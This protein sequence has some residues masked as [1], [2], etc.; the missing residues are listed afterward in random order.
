LT[1]R[2]DFATR[3]LSWWDDHGRKDLPWQQPRTPYRVWISEIMLQ[4]TQVATVIP[5][6][7]RFTNRFPDIPALAEASQDEVLALWAGLGYYA[8][9]RN[10]HKTARICAE[11]FDA[12]LPESTEEMI[13]LPGIGDSTAN[14]ILS[15]AHNV[16]AA[17]VDGNV[18]RVMA[19]HSAI[20][21]W[22]GSAPILKR[23]WHEARSRLPDSRAADYTQ[24]IM[25]LGAT[26]CT[27]RQ[28]GC[29]V[30]PVAEDCQAHAHGLVDLLPT[31]RPK[32]EVTEQQLNL[33]LMVRDDGRVLL[34]RRPDSGIW[35][36][37]W[38]LP[39]ASEPE[40]LMADNKLKENQLDALP[41]MEH[42]L[43]HRLLT[44]RPFRSAANAV[45]R[46]VHCNDD[47]RWFSPRE[48][49]QAGLPKPIKQLLKRHL[50]GET[51]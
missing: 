32:R 41:A 29:A 46:E 47:R 22:A 10:L 24:A 26:L 7:E 15:Q 50:T 42:R 1:K 37:L 23:L 2:T 5:Y 25:D 43:T 34:E 8:R 44:L 39:A 36:G 4:Q 48:L 33:L 19:R 27:R 16:P 18:R 17:V 45:T 13:R 12:Q 40:A 6:F 9:A 38:C 30:C 21:G 3:L 31:P 11:Q 51:K 35:G 49:R 28:P 20:E 14:A